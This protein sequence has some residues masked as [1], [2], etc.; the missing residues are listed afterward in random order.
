[1]TTQTEL[2]TIGGGHWKKKGCTCSWT[3]EEVGVA[4]DPDLE[5]VDQEVKTPD[6]NCPMAGHFDGVTCV[7]FSPDGQLVA[8][9]SYDKT[10]QLWNAADGSAECTLRGH[11]DSVSGVAFSPDGSKLASWSDDA[12]MKLWDVARQSELCNLSDP[13]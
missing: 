7:V 3:I 8:S 5:Y 12:T 11:S 1:M 2:C 10:V 6:P 13:T 9:S 4:G